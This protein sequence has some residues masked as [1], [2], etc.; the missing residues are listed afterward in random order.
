M[1]VVHKPYNKFKGWLREHGLTYKDI[2]D[3]LGLSTATVNAK[4]NGAS[5]FTLGEVLALM[6]EYGLD[7]SI[8]F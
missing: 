8:F 4:I 1:K 7:R 6:K 3:F 5:D 2:G